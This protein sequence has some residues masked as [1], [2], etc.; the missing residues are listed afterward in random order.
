MQLVQL[1][2][3]KLKLFA[4]ICRTNTPRDGRALSP[5]MVLLIK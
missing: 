5:V 2:L 3:K 1:I 4:H